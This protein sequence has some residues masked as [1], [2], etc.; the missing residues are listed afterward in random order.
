MAQNRVVRKMRR[1]SH[2]ERE[3]RVVQVR[4]RSR[5]VVKV[6]E[7]G[8]EDLPVVMAIRKRVAPRVVTTMSRKEELLVATV[9]TRKAVE[10]TVRKAAKNI[11]VVARVGRTAGTAILLLQDS[12]QAARGSLGVDLLDSTMTIKEG[13]E[14]RLEDLLVM[15]TTRTGITMEVIT[16][17]VESPLEERRKEVKARTPKMESHPRLEPTR[18]HLPAIP[19]K[20]LAPTQPE[21]RLLLATVLLQRPMG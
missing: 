21:R 15:T 3:R 1:E 10:S 8:R 11:D 13:M 14:S 12:T 20:H 17:R 19:K 6:R 2:R 5:W 16:I 4:R 7:G 9:A 18:H